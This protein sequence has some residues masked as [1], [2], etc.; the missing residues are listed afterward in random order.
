VANTLTLSRNGAVTTTPATALQFD[1][2]AQNSVVSLTTLKSHGLRVTSNF[3]C[4][5][6]RDRCT[7]RFKLVMRDFACKSRVA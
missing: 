6:E 5:N 3:H 7:Q 4:W 2:H 1:I